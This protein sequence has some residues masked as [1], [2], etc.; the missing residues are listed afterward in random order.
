MATT[1]IIPARNEQ[2]TIGSI[3][4]VFQAH[5]E[6]KDNVYVGIDAMTTDRTRERVED[7]DGVAIPYATHHGKG[8]VVAWTVNVL[9]VAG[10]ITRRVILCDGDYTGLNSGH[11]DRILDDNRRG[12]TIGVPDW[13][14]I[15]VPDHVT[16]AWPRVSGFRCLPHRLIPM[17]AHGY[18]LETQINIAVAKRFLP[19]RTVMMDG[20]K[21][22][23]QWPMSPRRMAALQADRE[24]GSLHGIL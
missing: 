19:V 1:V 21:S 12:M 7:A 22:P 17:D 13:P 16:M 2:D 8:E 11:V 24:W 15:D 6:T 10:V 14:E 23:F 3:V 5:P 4:R 20:L 9:R 18:L